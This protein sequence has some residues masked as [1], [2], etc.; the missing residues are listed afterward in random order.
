[1]ATSNKMPKRGAQEI[2]Q[3]K[4]TLK[5]SKPPIWRRVQ[6]RSEITLAQLHEV[7][8]IAMGWTDSHLH[9]FTVSGQAFGRPDFEGLEVRDEK[10]ASLWRLVGLRD[11]FVYEYDFGDGWEHE[12]VVE[13]VLPVEE[14]ALYPRCL[15]GKRAC[16][17]EDVGGIWG[18]Q[19]F[20]IAINDPTHPEHREMLEWAGSA[21]DP[22][23]FNLADV[24]LQ[25]L[26]LSRRFV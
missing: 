21:F 19:G 6:V 23:A 1:M 26:G 5:R 8:Q 3:L 24:N 12:I 17:P 2:Y 4:I 18:Y 13:K 20:L 22:A 25:L 11:S 16:P 14:G 9:Q 7:I 15:A 10:K